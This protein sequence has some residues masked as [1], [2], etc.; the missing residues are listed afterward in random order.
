MRLFD[1]LGVSAVIATNTLSKPVPGDASTQAGVG[2][3]E[4]RREALTAVD[5]LAAAKA[6]GGLDVEIIACG[7]ILDGESF[8]AYQRLGVKAAQYMVGTRLSRTIRGRHHR[9]RI[10]AT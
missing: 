8:R 2:G 9:K 10:G 1:E 5:Y 3:G 4:L 7:G 6:A